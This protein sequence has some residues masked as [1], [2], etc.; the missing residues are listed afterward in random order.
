MAEGNVEIVRRAYDLLNAGG[1]LD[2]LMEGMKPLLDPGAEWVNPPDALEV[3]T[4]TGFDGWRTALENIRT[5]LGEEVRLEVR[6]LVEGAD[7]V[8]ATGNARVR[9]TS[10]GIEADGPTWAA[11]WTVFNGRIR[12]YEWSWDPA[13]MR[14]RFLETEGG[15]QQGR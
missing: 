3:G 1:T 13:G 7:A 6:E 12:R 5:G 11:I 14:A 15:P 9:G 2:D 8:F 4:R 10:S